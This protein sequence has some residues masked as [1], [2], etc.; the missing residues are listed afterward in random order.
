MQ[1]KEDPTLVFVSRIAIRWGDMDVMGHVNNA[2]YFTY[3]EQARVDWLSSIGCAPA[4]DGEGPV[5]VNASCTFLRQLKYPGEIEIRTFVGE[6]GRSSIQTT[7]QIRRVD[8]P[9][10]LCA[11]GAAK[12][13]WVNFPLEKSQPLTPELRSR[14]LQQSQAALALSVDGAA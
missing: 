9:A 3:I 7:H 13:V 1:T 10:V 14:F 11:E 4:P 12:I 5:I 8:T 6:I 2:V